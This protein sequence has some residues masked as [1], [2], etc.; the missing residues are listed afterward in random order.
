M[1]WFFFLLRIAILVFPGN[2]S[3]NPLTP[4]GDQDRIS[5]YNINALSIRQVMR[6]KRNK[7]CLRIFWLIQ[8][9]ILRTS[10][11][12]IVWQTVRRITDEILGI[13]GLNW[14]KLGLSSPRPGC[15]N[16]GWVNPRL[17][18]NLISYLKALTLQLLDQICNSPY[19]QPH[20][21]YNVSS[22]N[23]VWN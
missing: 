9:Q 19:C 15:S 10:I 12:R 7:I 14:F 1:S 8:Y 11:I 20:N 23:L 6:I 21:S 3:F 18:W 4:M 22:E 13:K 5:P 16:V 17:E 2:E